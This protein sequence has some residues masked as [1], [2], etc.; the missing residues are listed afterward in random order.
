LAGILKNSLHVSSSLKERKIRRYRIIVFALFVL[1]A[2]FVVLNEAL[3]LPEVGDHILS[4]SL[5]L[6]VLVNVVL[7][8]YL[9]GNIKKELDRLSWIIIGIAVTACLMIANG[10]YWTLGAAFMMVLE[11]GLL[12]FVQADE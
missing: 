3:S 7:V 12:N 2:F 8:T 1:V 4:T 10:G 6:L 9:L 5:T 11:A